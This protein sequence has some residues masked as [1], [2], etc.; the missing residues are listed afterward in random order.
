MNSEFS[1][2]IKPFENEEGI[3]DGIVIP[4][5]LKNKVTVYYSENENPSRDL[6]DEENGW[7]LKEDITD[8]TKI[9]T[10]LI[11]LEDTII[12]VGS[13]YT[14]YYTAEIPFGVEFNKIAY[15]HHGIY[16]SLDTPEGKYRTS[17]EPNRIGVR[18]ADKYNLE[19]TKYQMGRNKKVEGA[20][21]KISKLNDSGE[22]EYSQTSVTNSE[23][24]LEMANLYAEKLYEITEIGTPNN[25][26]LSG[27]VIGI[28]GHINRTTG[29]LTIEKLYGE[30]R[31]EIEVQ[32]KMK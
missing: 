23:G 24:K 18:I 28:I 12:N 5:E 8:W 10:Y 4:E 29:E 20:T 27:D 11:D 21:Y 15:S 3:L 19:L 31:D 30:T 9:K 32:K 6:E 16:F 1:T 13:E 25:Y 7:K 14:F 17:T 26:E 22:V 2:T